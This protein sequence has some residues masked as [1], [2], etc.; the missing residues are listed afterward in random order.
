MVISDFVIPSKLTSTLLALEN[1]PFQLFMQIGTRGSLLYSMGYN[2]L[3][4]LLGFHSGLPSV[5]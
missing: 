2:M 4:L 3:L 5:P 1:N